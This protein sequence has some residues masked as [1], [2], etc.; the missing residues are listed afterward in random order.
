MNI[1]TPFL[2]LKVI[3]EKNKPQIA[4][5]IKTQEK[6]YKQQRWGENKEQKDLNGKCVCLG[7]FCCCGGGGGGTRD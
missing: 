7:C 2:L 3:G 1:I 4:D 6:V 5:K